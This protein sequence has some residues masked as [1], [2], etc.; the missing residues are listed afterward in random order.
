MFQILIF[1]FRGFKEVKYQVYT[2]RIF[3][4]AAKLITVVIFGLLGF[5]AIGLALSYTLSNIVSFIFAAYLFQKKVFPFVSST[6]KAINTTKELITYSLPMLFSGFLGGFVITNIDTAMIGFFKNSFEVGIYNAALPTARLTGI[7]FAPLTVIFLPL[8]SEL[9]SNNKIRDL[10]SVY[11]IT[12]KWIFFFLSPLLLILLFYPH[13]IINFLFGKNYSSGSNA[14]FFLSLGVTVRGLSSIHSS[15]LAMLKKTKIIF[16]ITTLAAS[17]NILLNWFLI[18][19]IGITGAAIASFITFSFQYLLCFYFSYRF[20]KLI[21][22]S[23]NLLKV[24]LA[25]LTSFVIFYLISKLLLNFTKTK[26]IFFLLPGY[27]GLY[28]IFILIFKTLEEEDREILRIIEKR[29]G[30]KNRTLR[31]IIIKFVR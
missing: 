20:T 11:K 4:N 19:R 18:Q 14:L 12:F 29:T 25:S 16:Y 7:V 15:V 9:Y 23:R 2:E 1:G 8:I 30:L 5:G 24:L 31:N 28:L 27:L 3:L 26:L 17:L 21:P 13:T 6:F 10:E 22:F